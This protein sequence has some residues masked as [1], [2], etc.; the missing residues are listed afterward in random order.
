MKNYLSLTAK[1]NKCW[2]RYMGDSERVG[3]QCV[4]IFGS[5]QDI[6]QQKEAEQELEAAFEEKNNIL[7]S[8][9]DAFFSVDRNWIIQY[10]NKA[11]EEVLGVQQGRVDRAKF[12][13]KISTR[14]GDELL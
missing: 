2:V 13:G 8:I 10:W 6:T 9:G 3:D 7:E 12:M 11:A 1:G 4:R 5:Y 14:P